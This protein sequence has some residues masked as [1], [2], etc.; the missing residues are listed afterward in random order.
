MTLRLPPQA[1]TKPAK[2]LLCDEDKFPEDK[3]TYEE[4]IIEVS[5]EKIQGLSNLFSIRRK[6]ILSIEFVY[7]E[8]TYDSA[9]V[10]GKK[11]KKSATKAQRLQRAAEAGLWTRKLLLG[12]L[13][14]IVGHIKEMIKEEETEEDVDINIEVPPHI[15][16]NI[17][18]N[19]RKRKADSSIDYR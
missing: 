18:E 3:Y 16:N 4:T 10:K 1:P 7:K 13:E 5:V 12:Q 6:I 14:E 8:V 11:K 17:L 9:I 15:I 2:S 19:N